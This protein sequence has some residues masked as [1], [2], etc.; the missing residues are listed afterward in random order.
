MGFVC[1]GYALAPIEPADAE[2]YVNL[3]LD[4]MEQTYD[5][6]YFGQARGKLHRSPPRRTQQIPRRLHRH[7]P[8]HRARLFAYDVPGWTPDGGLSC[9]I[10]AHRL[11]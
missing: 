1:Q 10:G 3:Q 7:P 2:K 8:P 4:C 6:I 11:G 5:P 9:S